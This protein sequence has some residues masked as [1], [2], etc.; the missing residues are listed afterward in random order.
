MLSET[1]E[2]GGGESSH[3]NA[4]VKVNISLNEAAPESDDATLR[5]ISFLPRTVLSKRDTNLK[6][7]FEQIPYKLHCVR[8]FK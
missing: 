4:L 3:S 6:R 2:T 5:E 1:I 7:H 8:P